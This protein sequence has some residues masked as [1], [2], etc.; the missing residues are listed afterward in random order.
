MHQIH[1]DST[2]VPMLQRI[3]SNGIVYGLYT[4][5]V[6]PS[7]ATVL[8]DLT[9]MAST[10]GYARVTVTGASYSITGVISNKAL[11]Q[12]SPISFVLTA[13][14]SSIYGYF[15]LDGT[16]GNLVGVAR[17]DTAPI[18]LAGGATITVLPVLGDS[19]LFSS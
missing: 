19:S 10:A 18:S 11:V 2:L 16:T 14:G 7:L 4:N 5:N 15:M 12:G 6:T 8:G 1:P 3:V 17:F 13:T 9:E